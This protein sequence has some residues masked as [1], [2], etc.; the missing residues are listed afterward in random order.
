MQAYL[1]DDESQWLAARTTRFLIEQELS[2]SLRVVGPV[3][4]RVLKP[5]V[6]LG[7]RP[8]SSARR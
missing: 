2:R 6:N 1:D 8:C 5:S 4:F 7:V 3:S